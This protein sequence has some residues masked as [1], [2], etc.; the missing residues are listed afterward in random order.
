MRRTGHSVGACTGHGPISGHHGWPPPSAL[1]ARTNR[2]LT[3]VV[4]GVDRQVQQAFTGAYHQMRG[5]EMLVIAGLS[6]LL[7]AAVAH[8]ASSARTAHPPTENMRVR[9]APS[10]ADR[11][12]VPLSDQGRRGGAAR[13]RAASGL[14]PAVPRSQPPTCNGLGV[15]QPSPRRPARTSRTSDSR[16]AVRDAERTARRRRRPS[17]GSRRHAYLALTGI[18]PG[19]TNLMGPMW[20]PTQPV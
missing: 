4:N 5:A 17:V 12:D 19:S 10:G 7:G 9:L 18:H 8:A 1:C 11:R 15:H 13:T 16:R 14:A 20:L 2:M 3:L 6:V